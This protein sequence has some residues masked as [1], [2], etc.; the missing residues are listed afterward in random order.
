MKFGL[1]KT[2]W[3]IF[4][5]TLL[6]LLAL[7]GNRLALGTNDEG[8]YLDAA[9]RMLHGQHLYADFF[10]YISPG[11]FWVQELF[12]RIFGVNVLAGRLPVLLYFASECALLWWMI[13][14]LG[15]RGAAWFALLVFFARQVSDLSF[16]TA[17]HRWDSGAISLTSIALAL[18]GYSSG[19]KWTWTAAGALG[20]LAAFF[21]PSMATVVAA[22][23]IWLLALRNLRPHILPYVVGGGA[24]GAA[25]ILAMAASGILSA[26]IEQMRWLSRNY[27]SVNVMAYGATIGGYR[28]LLAGPNDATLILRALTVLMIALPAILP[29]AAVA[30]WIVTL[31]LRPQTVP[32]VAQRHAILYL[33]LCIVGLVVSTYPRPDVMHLAWVAPVPFALAAALISLAAPKWAQGATVVAGIFGSALLLLFMLSTLGGVKLSTPVGELRASKDSAASLQQLFGAVKPGDSAFVYPYKP[34][35]YFLTQAKNPTRYSYLAP[36]MMN[37]RDE[38]SVLSDLRRSPPKWVLFLRLT[39]EEFLRVFPGGDVSKLH[40]QR[41]EA[42]I[43]ANYAP[44]VPDVSVTSYRLM[45]YTGTAAGR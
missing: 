4:G 42:W 31:F 33:V 20:A 18:H 29:V 40:F 26:F 27:S 21:T 22:T 2:A 30:G 24:T 25:L 15:S 32:K 43:D 38:Q 1:S 35:L 6:L 34:L 7:D 17:Q 14:R 28:N 11:V 36:G 45:Q 5:A 37:D 16:L 13:A 19:T 10:G 9:E 8:I 3:A 12:F 44:A 23:L 41:I 39:P